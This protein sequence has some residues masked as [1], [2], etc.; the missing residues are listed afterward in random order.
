MSALTPEERAIDVLER[1]PHGRITMDIAKCVAHLAA[2]IREAEEAARADEREAC[3]LVAEAAAGGSGHGSQAL[4]S[5]ARNIR[6]RGG[7]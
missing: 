7:R 3:A 4:K 5:A 2:A 6:A 1:W